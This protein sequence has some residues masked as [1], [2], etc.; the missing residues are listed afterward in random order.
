M[1]LGYGIEAFSLHESSKW[2]ALFLKKQPPKNLKYINKCASVV[3][4]LQY[5]RSKTISSIEL[6]GPNTK[7]LRG[8]II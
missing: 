8:Q 3:S 2:T 5:Q 6:S 7:S 4:K 1:A